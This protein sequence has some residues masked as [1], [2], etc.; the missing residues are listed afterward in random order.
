MLVD[1]DDVTANRRQSLAS[2]ADQFDAVLDVDGRVTDQVLDFLGGLGRTLG[3]L[4]DFLCEDSKAPAGIASTDRLDLSLK[5]QAGCGLYPK[6]KC[7]Q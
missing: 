7:D 6:Y 1:R 3:E 4:A 5:C 2:L